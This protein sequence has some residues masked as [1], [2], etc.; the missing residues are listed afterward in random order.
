MVLTSILIAASFVDLEWMII[1][2]SFVITGCVFGIVFVL[3]GQG[4]S[5]TDA[6]AGLF[7]GAGFLIALGYLSLWLLKK[8]GMGGGDIKLM[9]MAGLYLGWRYTL[10]SLFLASIMGGIISLGL[11][12]RDRKKLDAQI[13][14][15]PLLSLG[16]LCSV[17]F[18][19]NIIV[20]LSSY[21]LLY[22]Y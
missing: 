5:I 14:F 20:L 8:E 10:L 13:P 19:D 15:G 16:I 3:S 1:P 22:I 18:A 9:G 2:D 12:I 6:I 7:L 21:N 17:F 4:P 11:I